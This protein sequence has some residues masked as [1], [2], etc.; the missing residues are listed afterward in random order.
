M[1][2]LETTAPGQGSIIGLDPSL[3]IPGDTRDLV[4]KWAPKAITVLAL[5]LGGILAYGLPA[6]NL[7][8]G[9]TLSIGEVNKV[10]TFSTPSR[11]WVLPL[12]W[13][14]GLFALLM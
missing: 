3:V 9:N 8:D 1:A 14:C 7:T 6:L 12:S 10:L 11:G 2:Q 4:Q 13:F 5:L